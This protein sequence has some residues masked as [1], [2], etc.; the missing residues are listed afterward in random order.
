MKSNF[1]YDVA[2]AAHLGK[3]ENNFFGAGC[4]IITSPEDITTLN[5]H[6]RFLA[7]KLLLPWHLTTA[8]D[9]FFMPLITEQEIG[10]TWPP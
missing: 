5:I 7:T 6:F 9:S 3:D 10:S 4:E 8:E 1:R 2:R